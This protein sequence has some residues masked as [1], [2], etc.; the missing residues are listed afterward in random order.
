MSMRQRK[1]HIFVSF[2][3]FMV[4][5]LSAVGATGTL[6]CFGQDGHVTIEFAGRCDSAKERLSF[7]NEEQPDTCGPCADVR[8]LGMNGLVNQ[9]ICTCSFCAVSEA[10]CSEVA[11]TQD[12][13]AVSALHAGSPPF[14]RNL[15]PLKSVVL[16]I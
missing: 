7:A 16:L 5:V 11:S 15:E 14:S 2:W 13:P 3:L 10:E 9:G 4:L 8:F 1:R 12:E 6:L